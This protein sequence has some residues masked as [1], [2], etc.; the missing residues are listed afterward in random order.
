MDNPEK[1]ETYG[2]QDDIMHKTFQWTIIWYVI[3]I[4]WHFNEEWV[5]VV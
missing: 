1:L 5:I 4:T 3:H 2:T